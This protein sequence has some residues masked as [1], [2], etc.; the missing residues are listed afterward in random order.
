MSETVFSRFEQALRQEGIE[1]RR[2]KR[3]A[4]KLEP[5]TI[6]IADQQELKMLHELAKRFKRDTPTAMVRRHLRGWCR[7]QLDAIRIEQRI[8]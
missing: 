1:E 5:I 2:Q 7:E 3:E 8:A 6:T 4:E